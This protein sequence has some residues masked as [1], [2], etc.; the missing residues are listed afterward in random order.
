M[1]NSVLV[2]GI[3]STME[4]RNL[5]NLWGSKQVHSQADSLQLCIQLYI[6]CLLYVKHYAKH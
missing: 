1:L 2:L 4:I 6:Q 3:E 5:V